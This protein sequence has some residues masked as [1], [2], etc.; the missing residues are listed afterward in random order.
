MI[1]RCDGCKYWDAKSNNPDGG[2]VPLVELGNCT[3]AMPYW[4]ATEWVEVDALG[5]ERK[6]KPKFSD[7]RFFA[8]DGSDFRAD[9][10]TT[11]DFFCADHKPKETL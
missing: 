8:Q 5:I 11:P 2:S 6:L 9:V 10:Y 1:V 7:R 3:R 4:D